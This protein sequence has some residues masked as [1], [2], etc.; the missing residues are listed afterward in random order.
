MGI[1]TSR[2]IVPGMP[3][4]IARQTMLDYYIKRI[5]DLIWGLSLRRF[6]WRS[7][8]NYFNRWRIMNKDIFPGPNL[9]RH[10]SNEVYRRYL[11][12]V[13]AR[14][15]Q[16]RSEPASRNAYHDAGDFATDLGLVRESLGS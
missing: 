16:C 12:Y 8:G 7:P 10:S 9:K 15:C 11:D 3:L 5:D 2:R 1:H 6:R 14:L 4:Q 13:L